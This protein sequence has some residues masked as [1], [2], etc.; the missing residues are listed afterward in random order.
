MRLMSKKRTE[1]E[2]IDS[3]NAYL[4][5]TEDSRPER[6]AGIDGLCETEAG[7]YVCVVKPAVDRMLAFGGLL[8]LS[9][10]FAAISIAIYLDD[11]GPV[12]FTQKRVGKDKH[13]FELHKF[14]TMKLSAP[15]DVPTHQLQNPEQYI[16]KIGRIL[17][18]TSLDELPQIWDIFRGK[19]SI[20]GPRPALWN[21]EDLVAEREKYG[22][23]GILPGLTGLAQIKGRDELEIPEKARLDGVYVKHL[24]Q[25]GMKALFFDVECFLVTIHS[26]IGSDG[27]V[28]GGTGE[29]H[30]NMAAGISVND[31]YESAAFPVRST[32]KINRYKNLLVIGVG[33]YIG[34]F[35]QEYLKRVGNYNVQEMDAVNLVP[36]VAMFKG[37]D[38]VFYV[39]GIVHQKETKENKPLYYKVNRDLV[40][41]TAEAAKEAGVAHF[42]LL[43]SMSVYGMRTGHITKDTKAVPDTHYGRSKLQAD[44]MVWKMRDE[45]F[46]VSI[47][48]PPMVYGKGCKGNYQLLRKAAI[49]IPFFP[50]IK[51]KRSMIYIGNLCEFIKQLID[52]GEEGIFFPQNSQYV[53]TSEMVKTIADLNGK[54]MKLLKGFDFIFSHIT[55]SFIEKVFGNLIYEMTEPVNMY[56]FKK[57]MEET[58]CL[59]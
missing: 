35:L 7:A 3:G 40:T 15:H 20:I 53:C 6:Q 16:T 34:G 8:L 25:G 21:Q 38:V 46:R 18:R 42:I 4:E 28:E 32:E 58:E 27:V 5:G 31:M 51:N 13:F 52:K 37:F 29:M 59:S 12:L 49:K 41:D 11:P 47:L 19:M 23:N 45:K 39:A 14:R 54:K 24:E 44:E 57:S 26:V 48:R 56:D 50:D 1:P 10:L 33:S 2:D 55:I 36:D 9:P 30:K 17:R 43:S 22:A